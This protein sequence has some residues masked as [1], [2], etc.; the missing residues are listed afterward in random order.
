MLDDDEWPEADWLENF[1]A[2]ANETGV[3]ALH[4][5]VLPEF[6]VT[7]GRW[8]EACRGLSAWR[9]KTGP[10][11]MIHSTSNVLIRRSAFALIGRPYFDTRFA[12]SGGEDKERTSTT[13]SQRAA[14]S[15]AWADAA[16]VHARVP[17]SRSTPTLGVASARFVSAIRIC[18]CSSNTKV[19][20]LPTYANARRSPPHWFFQHA[21]SGL[22][23]APLASHRMAPLCKF[24]RATGKLAALFGARYDEYAVTHGR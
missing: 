5:A 20:Y 23:A 4:G 2:V 16:I 11:P 17:A 7:P 12:L 21:A 1:V 6:E 14:R 18:A 15:F 22:F 8:V 19:V 9:Q 3:D 13:S 10:A 24:A